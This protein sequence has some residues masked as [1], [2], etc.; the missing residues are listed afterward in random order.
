M[1][2]AIAGYLRQGV[3][4]SGLSYR[5]LASRSGLSLNRIGIIL[6][7]EPP[8]ATIG[9]MGQIANVLGLT[10]SALLSRAESEL[11]GDLAKP[12]TPVDLDAHRNRR[13]TDSEPADDE[14]D[15]DE[16]EWDA[17]TRQPDAAKIRP[18]LDAQ[19]GD[20]LPDEDHIA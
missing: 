17:S 15:F 16:S 7:Q 2:V 13:A 12:V 14:D 19:D 9:E 20:D 10:A 8:P 6:R 18:K 1:D 4:D 11:S 3:E 5:E